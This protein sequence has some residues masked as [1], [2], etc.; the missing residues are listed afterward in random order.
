MRKIKFR[1]IDTLHGKYRC[2]DLLQRDEGTVIYD[3]NAWHRIQPES[4]AQLVEVIDGTEIY[5]GDTFKRDGKT[6]RATL[7]AE[8]E[9]C[10]VD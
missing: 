4:V 8:Y 2:G 7:R 10:D 9:P 6:Y 1:G 5:T 3:G